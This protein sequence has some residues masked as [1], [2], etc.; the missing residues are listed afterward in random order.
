VTGAH[1]VDHRRIRPRNRQGDSHT[2]SWSPAGRQIASIHHPADAAPWDLIR[3]S[4]TNRGR[5]RLS[6][7]ATVEADLGDSRPR[8][9]AT[10]RVRSGL[11]AFTAHGA[12]RG[13]ALREGRRSWTHPWAPTISG[14]RRWGLAHR[15]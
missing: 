14:W 4:P 9:E 5:A 12:T 8:P 3:M 7:D 13:T 10:R 11:D 15:P 1:G 2:P 6:H